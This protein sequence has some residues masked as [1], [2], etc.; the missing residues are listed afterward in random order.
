MRLKYE[1]FSKLLARC[2][3]F[4]VIFIDSE[5]NLVGD[6]PTSNNLKKV[7]NASLVIV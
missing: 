3:I 1:K 6:T 2:C 5:K 4:F 7:L